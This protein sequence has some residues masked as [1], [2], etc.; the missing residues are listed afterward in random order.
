MPVQPGLAGIPDDRPLLFVG[1]HQ[2][3]APQTPLNPKT[4]KPWHASPALPG[5]HPRRPPPCSS[6]ATTSWVLPR[7]WEPSTSVAFPVI[8]RVS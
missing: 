6:W 5:W 8:F 4:P 3:G 1:N 2:V 7:T